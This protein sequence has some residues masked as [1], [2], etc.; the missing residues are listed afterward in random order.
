MSIED[1]IRTHW[2]MKYYGNRPFQIGGP[3]TIHVNS[4]PI[5]YKE[6]SD[7]SMIYILG[8][9]NM[10]H[11]PCFALDM[12]SETGEAVLQSVDH[13]RHKGHSLCFRDGHAIAR[14]IVRAAY[15]LARSRGM[16]TLFLT[17]KS[18]LT[19]DNMEFSLCDLSF[20]TTGKTWYESIFP[21]IRCVNREDIDIYRERVRTSTWKDVGESLIDLDIGNIDPTEPGSAMH[22]LNAMKEDKSFCWFFKKNMDTLLVNSRILSMNGTSWVC[23][24]TADRS[25]YRS[26]RRVRTRRSVAP[27]ARSVRRLSDDS[28]S[29]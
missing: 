8:G 14:D 11:A 2:F 26:T 1:D 17:D 18:K 23:D 25:R 15:Q 13:R 16:R 22:V 24:L 4:H 7:K 21:N 19:C 6:T 9:N 29:R 27:T 20:L 12:N 28:L 10:K 3:G 5:N